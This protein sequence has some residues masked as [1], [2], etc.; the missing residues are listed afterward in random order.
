RLADDPVGG[1][2]TG[3]V[4]DQRLGPAARLLS[5][6]RALVRR[7]EQPLLRAGHKEHVRSLRAEHPSRDAPDAAA[8]AGPDAGASAATEV[9]YASI[10]P[11]ESSIATS[12]ASSARCT[13]HLWAITTMR[14]R[15]SSL[16]SAEILVS[17][18]KSGGVSA[19]ALVK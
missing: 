7:L 15:C 3:D 10:R 18:L 2:R 5:G 4:G 13:G 6:R 14:S 17:T 16:S 9:H 12:L 1:I 19:V 8:G 11:R